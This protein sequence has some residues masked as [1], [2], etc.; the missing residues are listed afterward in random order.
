MEET[1]GKLKRK[2]GFVFA[3]LPKK[4]T[5]S[6]T[7]LSLSKFHFADNTLED[8]FT[9]KVFSIKAIKTFVR[10]NNKLTKSWNV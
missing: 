3:A 9:R 10:N 1:E 2:N 8:L 5:K 7:A 4:R 6:P